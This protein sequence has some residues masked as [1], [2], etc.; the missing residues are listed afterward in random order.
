MESKKFILYQID[1]NEEFRK[2]NIEY[3]KTYKVTDGL[4]RLEGKVELV[5]ID[6]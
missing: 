4:M 1:R 2:R 5:F 6:E 3:L